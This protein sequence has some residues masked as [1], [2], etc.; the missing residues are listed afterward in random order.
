MTET[1]NIMAHH[2]WNLELYLSYGAQNFESI[3]KE[4]GQKHYDNMMN[5]FN[6]ILKT[7]PKIR[8]VGLKS[9]DDICLTCPKY[10]GDKCGLEEDSNNS[11]SLNFDEIVAKM[12]NLEF[13][14]E[15]EFPQILNKFNINHNRRIALKKWYS[16]EE[17]ENLLLQIQEYDT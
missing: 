11:V 5:I 13:G 7:K 12:Y 17:L 14:E 6:N 15:Y 1:V 3:I 8:V 2:L 16:G 4:Y 10:T 9:T